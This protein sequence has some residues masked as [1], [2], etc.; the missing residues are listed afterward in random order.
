[1][2]DEAPQPILRA[3]VRPLSRKA[4]QQPRVLVTLS[5]R[6][7]YREG[8]PARAPEQIGGLSCTPEVWAL[9]ERAL[10]AGLPMLGSGVTVETTGDEAKA[11]ASPTTCVG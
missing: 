4:R 9:L 7:P 2:C 11:G 5:L 6:A 1:M 8:A 10:R 3:V